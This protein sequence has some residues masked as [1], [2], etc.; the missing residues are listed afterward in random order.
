MQIEGF[1]DAD[2]FHRNHAACA[3]VGGAGAGDPAIEMAADHD[4]LILQLGISAGDFGYRV[5]AVLVLAGELCVDVDFERYRHVVLDHARQ[6][7]VMLN[8]HHGVGNLDGVLGLLRIA[9]EVGSVVVEDDAGTA[10]LT[11]IARGGD[12]GEHALVG[13]HG[14]RLFAERRLLHALRIHG[15]E[16]GAGEREAA[17]GLVGLHVLQLVVGVAREERLGDVGC[18]T[19]GA[20]QNDLAAQLALQRLEV[21]GVG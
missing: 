11:A 15:A 3:V 10:A 17:A 5:E 18:G 19:H 13:H 7:V 14:E 8:H 21:L 4:D 20:Q 9:R 16:G 12:D 2:G 6:A 1:E